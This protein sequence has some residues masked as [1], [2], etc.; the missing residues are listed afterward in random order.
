MAALS[1]IPESPILADF[2]RP[3]RGVSKTSRRI[4]PPRTKQ[5]IR[6]KGG[7]WKLAATVRN[8]PVSGKSGM[9][10]GVTASLGDVFFNMR[11]RRG[12][13]NPPG[14]EEGDPGLATTVYV[15][16]WTG[17]LAGSGDDYTYKYDRVGSLY[18]ASVL[19]HPMR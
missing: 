6:R 11:N 3:G 5:N 9:L 10:D 19:H 2:Q 12:I 4:G 17:D 13:N 7:N 16:I 14:W 8:S 1:R 15:R 18:Y